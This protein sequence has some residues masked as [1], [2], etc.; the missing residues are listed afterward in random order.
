MWFGK[1]DGLQDRWPVTPTGKGME[2]KA[3][4]AKKSCETGSV[5]RR[6]PN[7]NFWNEIMG[8]VYRSAARRQTY[9]AHF[10]A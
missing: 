1:V 8:T 10:K 4:W 9:L 7:R 6:I 5:R 3:L 2:A